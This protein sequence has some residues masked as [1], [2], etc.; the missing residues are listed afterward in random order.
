[1]LLQRIEATAMF[2]KVCIALQKQL[3]EAPIF[4]IHDCLVTT[5]DHVDAVKEIMQK[6]ISD[7]IGFKASVSEERWSDF[8]MKLPKRLQPK[9]AA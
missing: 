9:I 8:C 7:F 2:S 4:T 6:A 1:M 3:P 5:V